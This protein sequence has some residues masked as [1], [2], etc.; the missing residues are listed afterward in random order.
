[1]YYFVHHK[2]DEFSFRDDL[3]YNSKLNISHSI[4][5]PNNHLLFLT[6]FLSIQA[7]SMYTPLIAMVDC[8]KNIFLLYSLV[9]WQ[10]EREHSDMIHYLFFKY[11]QQQTQH[12]THQ[13]D[14]EK[15]KVQLLSLYELVSNGFQDKVQQYF[16]M[17]D[18]TSRILSQA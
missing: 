18:S 3:W 8:M 11:K 13:V 14:Q 10:R 2:N 6:Y 9:Q 16:S 15:I 1:M 4:C 12:Q 7:V 17:L 5:S